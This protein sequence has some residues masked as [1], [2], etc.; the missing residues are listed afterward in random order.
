MATAGIEIGLATADDI[1]GILD[2]QER[3]LRKNGGALSVPLSREWL[4]AAIGKMPIVVARRDGRVVGYVVSSSLADQSADPI[5][6]GMLQAYPGSPGSYVYGPI[7]V[8]ESERGRGVARVMFQALKRQLPGREGFTFIRADNAISRRVHAG[9]GMGEA[10]TFTVANVDY[11]V[12][13]YVG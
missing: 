7:C 2:L 4:D 1:A 3:N 12:V 11:V 9:M 6:D 13:A 5:L 10:A 8:A